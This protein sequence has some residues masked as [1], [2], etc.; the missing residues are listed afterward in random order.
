VA[1]G[2]SWAAAEITATVGRSPAGRATPSGLRTI[3]TQGLY[4]TIAS[5]AQG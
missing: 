3:S 4:S 2:R 1:A 5:V